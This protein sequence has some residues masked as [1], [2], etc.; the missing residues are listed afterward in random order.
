MLRTDNLD[1][2]GYWDSSEP[3]FLK[4]CWVLLGAPVVIILNWQQSVKSLFN[5]VFC[6]VLILSSE[7]STLSVGFLLFV[8]NSFI[9]VVCLFLF[10]IHSTVL[11]HPFVKSIILVTSFGAEETSHTYHL[12]FNVPFCCEPLLI[13][14]LVTFGLQVVRKSKAFKCPCFQ[15]H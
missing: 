8:L 12:D 9:V 4:S 10:M 1:P 6:C 11:L 7:E 15:C 5:E 3:R 2:V 13:S 14:Q